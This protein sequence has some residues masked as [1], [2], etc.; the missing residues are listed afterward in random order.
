MGK[1]TVFNFMTLDGYFQ[2]LDG[3]ISWHRHGQEESQ[4]ASDSMKPGGTLVFGRKTYEM[5][6]CYWPTPM[7][8][9]TMPDVAAGM[10]NA[11]KIVFS[12]TLDEAGWQNTRLIKRDM[13]DEMKRLKWEQ[14]GDMT[15]LG[16][17]SLVTQFAEAGLVD[18]FGFM[19][20][21]VAIGGGSPV[22]ANVK[23]KLDLELIDS[24]TFKSG[25][26]LLTYAPLKK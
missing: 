13:I 6:A 25:T 20:D 5:M 22:F 7:A 3:D 26:V 9:E 8:I 10:N 16:S 21:P 23:H 18:E 1:L 11:Q 2:G 17:G 15:I 12:K 19:I 14:P 4:F 24:R